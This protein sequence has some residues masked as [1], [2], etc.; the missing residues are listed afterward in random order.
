MNQHIISATSFYNL[1]LCPRRVYLDLYGNLEEKGE[2]SDFLQLLWEKGLR[3][4]RE[5]IDKYR[6][7][8]EVFDVTGYPGENTADQTIELMRQGVPLIYQGVLIDGD[9]VGRPDLLEKV[10][11]KS[12][13]RIMLSVGF[14]GQ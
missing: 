3:I 8:K 7:E 1:S 9:H 2:Y 5:I 11:G 13:P 4:E 10:D 6:H 14:A 12:S